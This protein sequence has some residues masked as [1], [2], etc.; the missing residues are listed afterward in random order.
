MLELKE[1]YNE[2]DYQLEVNI[3]DDVMMKINRSVET[4]KP[5][6]R[7]VLITVLILMLVG[8]AFIVNKV[9]YGPDGEI[10]W[11]L[12]QGLDDTNH[13]RAYEIFEELHLEEGEIVHILI[14]ENNP[15]QVITSIQKPWTIEN[16]EKNRDSTEKNYNINLKEKYGNFI[17]KKSSLT[18]VY[19]FESDFNLSANMRNKLKIDGDVI[20]IQ[21]G[22]IDQATSFTHFYDSDN[23]GI[24]IIITQWLGNEI[25]TSDDN[26]DN[27]QTI[28]VNGFEGLL[29]TTGD[30]SEFII[31]KDSNYIAL[32]YPI[33]LLSVD[34]LKSILSEIIQ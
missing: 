7:Y 18:S 11:Q 29:R 25:F 21:K 24:K 31:I 28:E 30:L 22:N 27:S 4:K 10:L 15:D 16:F 19:D 14:K 17:Y 6:V 13:E 9:F 20:E 12:N 32:R 2:Q 3:A 26:L 33:N 1:Y 23:G 5:N 34:E 8:C